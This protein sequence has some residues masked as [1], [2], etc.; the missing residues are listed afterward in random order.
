M[1]VDLLVYLKATLLGKYSVDMSDACSVVQLADSKV[2]EMAELKDMLR[3]VLKAVYL[4]V[5]WAN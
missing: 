4:A 5:L 2:V 1:L 3:V